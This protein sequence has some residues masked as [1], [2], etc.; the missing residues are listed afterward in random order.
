MIHF[1]PSI[2]LLPV[3]VRCGDG[4]T[5]K[6]RHVIFTGSLGVLKARPSFFDPPLS[7]K[8]RQAIEKAGFGSTC[9][10]FLQFER[11]F[12]EELE[13]PT[14]GFQTLWLNRQTESAVVEDSNVPWYRS[15]LGLDA[16]RTHKNTLVLWLAGPR[17]A[18]VDGL[19]DEQIK[20]DV[21]E[22]LRKFA[23][24]SSIPKPVRVMR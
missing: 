11:P 24:S 6:A 13:P 8:K 15:A 18:E 21:V 9:K 14:D 10:I 19:S 2:L 1:E 16:I 20:Q 5:F 4:D 17:A 23:V 7:T 3:T 12:W 22:L